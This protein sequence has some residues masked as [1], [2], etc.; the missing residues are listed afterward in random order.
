MTAQGRARQ[1]WMG[2][3]G[4]WNLSLGGMCEAT[5][6]ALLEKENI[7]GG[8]YIAVMW[9][10]DSIW[11][12]LSRRLAFGLMVESRE[13]RLAVEDLEV[14]S[15]E[16]NCVERVWAGPEEAVLHVPE[17]LDIELSNF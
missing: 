8:M 11:M 9:A 10:Q 4:T 13:R 14:L 17:G 2:G 3:E 1:E 7:G 5:N 12:M 16:K 15:P 6:D